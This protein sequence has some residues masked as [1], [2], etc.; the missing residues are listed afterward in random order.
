MES[1]I[2]ETT[3]DI[4]NNSAQECFDIISKEYDHVIE[5]GNKLDNKVSIILAFTG[6]I[7]IVALELLDI[8]NIVKFPASKT[9]FNSTIVYLLSS[10]IAI[11]LYT[12]SISLYLNI[13]LPKRF[14]RFQASALL[15]NQLQKE[16]NDVVYN[17]VSIK[18]CAAIN[19]N[20]KILDSQYA[21]LSIG[22]ILEIIAVIL[23]IILVFIKSVV[24]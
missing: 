3:N 5:R 13:L 6:I 20:N 24:L 17:Y 18:Y 10:M 12:I 1:N 16:R 7:F 2:T 21:K 11:I 15:E 8:F 19:E 23:S 22:I 9:L 14:G 4:S